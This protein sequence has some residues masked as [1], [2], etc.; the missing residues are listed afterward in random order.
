[1]RESRFG[2]LS[3]SEKKHERVRH[4]SA[5]H[6]LCRPST[7]RSQTLEGLTLFVEFVRQTD[8]ILELEGG[9]LWRSLRSA[10]GSPLPPSNPIK[11]MGEQEPIGIRP[12]CKLLLFHHP[13]Q[14]NSKNQ[15]LTG[16]ASFI[17]S[18]V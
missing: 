17:Y 1:M 12:T 18:L 4:R 10:F 11:A 2:I 14:S 3:S 9:I 7:E 5:A 6:P 15:T 16:L 13:P 8:E